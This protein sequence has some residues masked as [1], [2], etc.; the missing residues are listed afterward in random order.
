MSHYKVTW[1]DPKANKAGEEGGRDEAL[2]WGAF[3]GYAREGY[4]VQLWAGGPPH[5]L[6]IAETPN[7]RE[8]A[9]RQLESVKNYLEFSVE[10]MAKMRDLYG[11]NDSA[12]GAAVEVEQ[13]GKALR[14]G[15]CEHFLTTQ[16]RA[17]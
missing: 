7:I 11:K 3:M 12:A 2:A 14:D 10:H 1:Y 13:R 4:E 15:I 16:G 9:E 5:F 17:I 8:A 6:L